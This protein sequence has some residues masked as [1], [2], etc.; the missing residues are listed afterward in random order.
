MDSATILEEEDTNSPS[1]EG[2]ST[3]EGD[4]SDLTDATPEDEAALQVE[5]VAEPAEAVAAGAAAVSSLEGLP[6]KR[7]RTTATPEGRVTEGGSGTPS[8]DEQSRADWTAV[9]GERGL[10]TPR[11]RRGISRTT[12]IGPGLSSSAPGGGLW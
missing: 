7:R 9:T 1:D 5:E 6:H 11:A 4:T 3:D 8:G 12:G 2:E 10:L